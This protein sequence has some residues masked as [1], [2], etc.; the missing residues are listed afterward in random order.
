MLVW[1]GVC[2]PSGADRDRFPR[3]REVIDERALQ[4]GCWQPRSPIVL[5]ATLT[6]GGPAVAQEKKP[7]IILIVADDHG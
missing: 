3:A 1:F 2:E 5:A 7:N 4:V 6:A